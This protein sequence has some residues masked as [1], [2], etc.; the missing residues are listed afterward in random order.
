M[1]QADR[2]TMQRA[3]LRA[4]RE[5]EE[6]VDEQQRTQRAAEM[7][8]AWPMWTRTLADLGEQPSGAYFAPWTTLQRNAERR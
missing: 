8:L 5:F 2:P 7:A 4:I 6:R 1:D 3:T